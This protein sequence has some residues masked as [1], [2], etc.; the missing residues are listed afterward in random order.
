MLLIFFINS[1]VWYDSVHGS[2]YFELFVLRVPIAP[3]VRLDRARYN[4]F[5]SPFGPILGPQESSVLTRRCGG[6]QSTV[7]DPKPEACCFCPG[8]INFRAAAS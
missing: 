5:E 8:I 4:P 2:R 6:P 7:R 3:Q 1:D